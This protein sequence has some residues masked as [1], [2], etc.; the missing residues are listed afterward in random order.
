MIRDNRRESR[1]PSDYHCVLFIGDTE[2]EAILSDISESGMKVIIRPIGFEDFD[3]YIK[4]RKKIKFQCYI[5]NDYLHKH[6]V[7]VE[8][9]GFMAHAHKNDDDSW[10]VGLFIPRSESLNELVTSLR[11]DEY[12]KHR[13]N[14]SN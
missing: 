7:A 5:G 10:N 3:S 6:Y 1:L 8:G 14:S 2:V 9:E 4:D 13:H 11:V 12:L